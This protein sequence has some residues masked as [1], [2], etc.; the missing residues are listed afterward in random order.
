M[1]SYCITCVFRRTDVLLFSSNGVRKDFKNGAYG[2]REP[3]YG[4][5]I[6]N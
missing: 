2:G 3:F 6:F 1:S 4:S 5:D